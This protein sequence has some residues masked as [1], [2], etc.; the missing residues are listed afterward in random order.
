MLV[1]GNAI[2]RDLR[3]HLAREVREQ[4][5]KVSLAVFL[6]EHSYVIKKFV[7][8]KKRAAD[9]IGIGFE[10]F[11]TE[12]NETT[13]DFVRAVLAASRDHDGI[14]VQLPITASVDIDTLRRI[15]PISHDVDVYGFTA[16]Q[17]FKEQRLPILPPVVGAMSEILFRQ[18][19]SI[20]G[21]KVAIVG[22]GP[23]VG[24]PAAVWAEH[25]GAYVSQVTKSTPNPAEITQD[26]DIVILGAGAPGL[27]QPDMVKQGVIILDAGTS[28]SEGK[29]AGDADPAC[30]E[31]A[32]LMTPV[33]GGIG[34]IA[35]AKVF[36]NLLALRRLRDRLK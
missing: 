18:S 36:E 30:E 3:A 24:K 31:K 26:A 35:V 19:I 33:P 10:V 12:R 15:L 1:D 29:I 2:A 14:L 4:K 23:L 32:S 28:E 8:I 17:Q 25:S 20:A 11:E 7:D 34:P 13:E 22:D 5:M 16:F 21:R 9:D 6:T 27:L